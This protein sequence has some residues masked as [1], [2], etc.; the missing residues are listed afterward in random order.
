MTWNVHHYRGPKVGSFNT[1]LEAI[2]FINQQKIPSEYYREEISDV[3]TNPEVQNQVLQ[4][5]EPTAMVQTS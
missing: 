3:P 2:A 1:E 5:L 4:D